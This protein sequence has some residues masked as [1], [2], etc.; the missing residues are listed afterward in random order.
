M[1]AWTEAFIP[2]VGWMGFDPTN[3]LRVDENYIKVSH[4]ADY[5][6][7]APIKGVLKTKGENK[8]SYKVVVTQQQQ[9]S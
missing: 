2:G 6:D 5:T 3:N 1:H 8:T 4:G 7:C 9:Q